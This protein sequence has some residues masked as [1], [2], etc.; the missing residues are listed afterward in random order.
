MKKQ[1]EKIHPS[2]EHI[3]PQNSAIPGMAGEHFFRAIFEQA[4]IGVAQVDTMTGRFLRVN[5]HYCDILGYTHAEMTQLTLQEIT[6]QGDLQ[7]NLDYLKRLQAGV[8]RDFAIEKRYMRKDGSIVWVNLTVS[9]MWE[10]GETPNYHIA[11]VEDI[12]QRKK[13]ETDLLK[14]SRAVEQS[15]SS[16]LITDAHGRIEFVNP[17]FTRLSGYSMDEVLGKN[18]SISK[19]GQTSAQ[20]Y[21]KMWQIITSGKEWKG[22]LQ[23]RTKDGQLYWVSASIS[24][25]RDTAGAITHFL[26][27]QEDITERKRLEQQLFRQN[28]YLSALHEISLG[29]LGHLDI[30]ELLQDLVTRA[31]QVLQAQNGCI[32][33]V[34]KSLDQLECMFGVGILNNY[35][36]ICFKPGEGIAGKVWMTA[37]PLIIEDYPSWEGRS[38]QIGSKDVRSV[39]GIPLISGSQAIG[40]LI[41]AYGL[42]SERVFR[43]DE[44]ALLERLAN[45]AS[46]SIE[47][48]RLFDETQRLFKTEQQRAAELAIMVKASET[49]VKNIGLQELSR[50]IGDMV[51]EIFTTDATSILLLDSQNQ[52]IQPLYE[53]DEGQYIEN[54]QPFPLGQGLTSR[55]I[56][57]RQPLLIGTAQRSGAIRRL[58]SPGSPDDQSI[59]HP[60]LS[61]RAD[62]GGRPY[63]GGA[64]HPQ[65]FAER[66]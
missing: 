22:E 62:P 43:A 55:V 7:E 53:F 35:V 32:Y 58:L 3:H 41:L 45:L 30:N 38:S 13:T 20:E 33:L 50:I 52:V 28:N 26:A 64:G 14:F 15:V 57:T 39:V 10:A 21:E 66:F 34:N 56:Q 47:N 17:T 6:Y 9:P 2:P 59:R 60:V 24:P 31:C 23:N 1:A 37:R 54:L 4:A 63:P 48:A 29:I 65:L 16:V 46:I 27:I 19:S 42:D 12:T 40:V 44:V 11:V 49:M 25:I 18:P 51:T 5:Q 8:I 61:W 36:G